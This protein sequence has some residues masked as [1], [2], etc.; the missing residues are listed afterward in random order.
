LGQR[1]EPFRQLT[2]DLQL[3]ELSERRRDRLTNASGLARDLGLELRDVRFYGLELFAQHMH[4]RGVLGH[5]TDGDEELAL[6]LFLFTQERKE[7]LADLAHGLTGIDDAGLVT[8]LVQFR[9]S[10][11]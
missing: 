7:K 3:L 11:L 2:L 6:E 9:Q 4:R 5:L 8:K 10:F 1:I